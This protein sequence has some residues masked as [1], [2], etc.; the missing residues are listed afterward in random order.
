MKQSSSG[1]VRPLALSATCAAHEC[2]ALAA[3]TSGVRLIQGVIRTAQRVQSRN[4]EGLLIGTMY[5]Q[6]HH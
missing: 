3:G 2:P 4:V 1:M 6:M 5:T